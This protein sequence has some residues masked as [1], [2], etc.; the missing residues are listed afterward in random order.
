MLKGN[1][2]RLITQFRLGLSPLRDE[3]FCYNITDDPFCSA[4]LECVESLSHYIFVC[5]VYS[6]QREVMLR[7]LALLESVLNRNFDYL[8]DLNNRTKVITI[9]TRGVNLLNQDQSTKLNINLAVSNIFATF[10][11]C[12]F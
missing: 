6:I 9:L 7:E 12:S 10:I 2:G 1:T 3:L 8:I 4:C 11:Q 5:P